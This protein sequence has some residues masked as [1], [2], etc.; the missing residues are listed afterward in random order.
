MRSKRRRTQH[1]KG[2][3]CS[4]WWLSGVSVL[5]VFQSRVSFPIWIQDLRFKIRIWYTFMTSAIF[6]IIPQLKKMKHVTLD[7][8]RQQASWGNRGFFLHPYLL[9]QNIIDNVRS[10]QSA[11]SFPIWIQNLTQKIKIWYRFMTSAIVQIIPRLKKGTMWHGR[12]R[13]PPGFR[14]WSLLSK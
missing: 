11:V 7:D 14:I 4:S 6:Q 3:P 10:K 1:N 5:S 12:V 2:R 13:V 9:N 8:F